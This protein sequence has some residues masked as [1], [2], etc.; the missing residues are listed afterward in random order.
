MISKSANYCCASTHF[1]VGLVV[2]AEVAIGNP[3]ELPSSDYNAGERAQTEGFHSTKGVGKT[4][5]NP[6]EYVKTK[7]GVLVPCGKPLEQEI[8][9][10][11]LYNEY[12]VYDPS[13]VRQ[14]YIFLRC[15]VQSI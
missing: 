6:S 13:Q 2:L 7:D 14:R 11:L 3:L 15:D 5:P 4:F 12:I 8:A 9:S 10:E 1:P